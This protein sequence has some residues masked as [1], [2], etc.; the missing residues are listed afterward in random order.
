VT[1]RSDDCEENGHLDAFV[2]DRAQLLQAAH[3]ACANCGPGSS[4]TAEQVVISAI[5][6]NFP[7][8]SGPGQV[9]LA[10]PYTVAAS[11]I[12][13]RIAGFDDLRDGV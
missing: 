3:G 12:A 1:G 9:W 7:G 2:A 8:R 5:N 4:E 6:R 10:S 13:G 11:A